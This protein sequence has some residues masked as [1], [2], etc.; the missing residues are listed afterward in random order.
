MHRAVGA[1]VSEKK[2]RLPM[3]RVP[4]LSSAGGMRLIGTLTG[5]R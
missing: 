5:G 4:A 1:S 2:W 3:K